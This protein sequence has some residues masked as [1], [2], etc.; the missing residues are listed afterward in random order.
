VISHRLGLALL[1]ALLWTSGLAPATAQSPDRE[2]SK[3]FFSAGA[4]AYEMGDYLAAIQALDSAWSITPLPAIAFSLAQAERRQYFV[5]R[6]RKHLE[7][8]ISLFRTYLQQVTNG[9]RRADATDALAQL[10]PLAVG[11]PGLGEPLADPGAERRTR[12]MISSSTPAATVS[13]DDGPPAP[14]PLIA[15]VTPGNHKLVV[16]ADGYF[17]IERTATAIEGELM[18]LEIGLKERPAVVT[19]DAVPAAELYVDG[20]YA[21]WIL[22]E[23]RLELASGAHLLSFVRN[24]HRVQAK[25]LRLAPGNN[26]ALEVRLQPTLQRTAAVTL[27]IVSGAALATGAVLTALA[28][29]RESAASDILQ[30]RERMN[31]T[32]RELDSY[33]G[34]TRDRERFRVAAVSG[35]VISAASLTIAMLLFALDQP[36]LREQA[37]AE[38]QPAVAAIA[39]PE[40]FAIEGRLRF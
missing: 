10:E 3:K 26:E 12:M 19:V 2:Q 21:G 16:S 18:P 6:D 40:A 5:S 30:R 13:L 27:F 32:T 33:E 14:A 39:L 34:A 4:A 28:V 22:S 37:A 11:A 15:E 1:L 35:F 17:P 23:K 8:A 9:G 29:E 36:D 31:L 20:N 24:G 25:R 7:R 38:P